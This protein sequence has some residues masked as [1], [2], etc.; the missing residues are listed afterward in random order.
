MLF[1]EDVLVYI[2]PTSSVWMPVFSCLFQH[3]VLSN[4]LIFINLMSKKDVSVQC[5]F[6]CF[7]WEKL[8]ICIFSFLEVLCKFLLF[9]YALFTVL[10]KL[11]HTLFMTL[12]KWGVFLIK[13]F[14]IVEYNVICE[15]ECCACAKNHSSNLTFHLGKVLEG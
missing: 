1:L 9:I 14:H 11:L 3:S 8:T 5:S 6:A 15:Y 4:F 7:F 10:Y 2:C 12:E 13:P